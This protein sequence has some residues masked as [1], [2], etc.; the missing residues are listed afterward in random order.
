MPHGLS[1]DS[2]LQVYNW[3]ERHLKGSG[4]PVKEEPP[5]TPEP[6]ATLWI[7][8]T[9]N[10]VTGL[11]SQTPFTLLKSRNVAVTPA[12]LDS[13][14]GADRPDSGLRARVLARVPSRAV[15]IEALDIASAP[16]VFVPAWLF[17]PRP[18]ER[19]KAVVLALDPAGR[20]VRW[21][22]GEIYQQLAHKGYA[23]CAADVRGIGDLA[24]EFG[25]GAARYAAGH[26]AEEDYA[27]A[28]LILGKSLL[29]QRVTDIL[30]IAAALRSLPATTGKTLASY[31]KDRLTV[32]ALCAAALDT[33][34]QEIYLS[35]GLVSYQS[36]VEVENYIAAFSNFCPSI[37]LHTDLPKIASKLSPRKV[38]LAGMV[39]GSGKRMDARAVR[40][41]YPNATVQAEADWS[42][43]DLV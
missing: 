32:P 30:A 20:N 4:N 22:E 25:R 37:L 35:G 8:K 14:I 41:L 24:P 23:V 33:S 15:D 27:W 12:S 1:Y 13:L 34:I 38:T 7:T 40:E 16:D 2:R 31:A 29:G 43:R 42:F 26:H 28:S 17:L 21:H 5:V 19:V 9:G 39:D 36:I 10:A 18:V 6:D 11:G 3:F